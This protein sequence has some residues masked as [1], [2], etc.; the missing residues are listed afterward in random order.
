[1]CLQTSH[2]ATHNLV[3]KAHAVA[4]AMHA[5]RRLVHLCGRANPSMP[6]RSGQLVRRHQRGRG[7]AD[8]WAHPN[9]RN[10]GN[11]DISRHDDD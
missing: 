7:G 8:R 11:A 6:A 1:M 9:R 5:W 2:P 10:H 3:C 4:V